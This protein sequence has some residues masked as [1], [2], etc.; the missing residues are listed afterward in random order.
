MTWLAWR[1]FRLQAAAGALALAAAAAALL[2]TGLDLRHLFDTSGAASCLAHGNCGVGLK[3]G[4]GSAEADFL[5][6]D[7]V[8]RYLI[9]PVLLV[10]PGIIGIFWGA[11]LVA[12]ELEGGTY[13]LAWTQSV[14]RTRWLAVKVALLGLASMA[15]AELFSLLVS[16]WFSP[17]DAVNLNRFDPGTF[18]ERGIVAIGYAALAFAIGV[19]AGIVLRRTLTAMATTL[20]A[21]VGLRLALTFGVR[22]NLEAPAHASMSVAVGQ[23]MGFLASPTAITPFVTNPKIAN[24][25]IRS[26][27]VVDKAGHAPGKTTLQRLTAHLCPSL[28]AGPNGQ[29][30]PA[31]GAFNACI[32]KLAGVYHVVVSYQPASRFW[33]FQAYEL[34]ICLALAAILLGTG[35]W[36]LNRRL[37]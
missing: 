13:R 28:L 12:R 32:Q 35:F 27:S 14:S 37:V 31:P 10:V 6:N 8:L 1:Q 17:V 19:L 36:W 26:A 11:P 34:V 23:N 5:S 24:A 16:W 3:G 29:H 25:W 22:P 15:L 7:R 21:F 30:Q 2:I 4:A 9:G 18:D 33:A 20:V